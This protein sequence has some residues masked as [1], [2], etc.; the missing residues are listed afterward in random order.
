MASSKKRKQPAAP[1]ATDSPKLPKSLRKG[2]LP[3]SVGE[4]WSAGLGALGD[5]RKQGGEAFEALV[6]RGEAIIRKG[7]DAARG[8]L[9]EVEEAASQV[10]DR[11]R[12]TAD[13]AADG[14]QARAERAV[15]AALGALGV[16]TRDEVL[17]LRAMVDR[18]DAQLSALGAPSASAKATTASRA[19]A[20]GAVTEYEVVRH[21]DGWALRKPGAARALA[22][23]K[24]KKEALRDARAQARDHPPSRL[25]V[26]NL[27]GSVGEVAEY[28]G[29]G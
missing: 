15:E 25:T 3:R 7:S 23:S 13:E 18:L 9:G 17:E 16:P 24:T 11:V 10:T 26:Y 5:A 22:V 8:A 28:G 14:V 27:D 1:A 21:A 6:A 29:D 20:S 12:I 19:P 2:A 4:V